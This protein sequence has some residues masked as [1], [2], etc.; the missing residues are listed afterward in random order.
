[1]AATN[2]ACNLRGMNPIFS[3]VS[4]AP[5]E[6]LELNFSAIA[7]GTHVEIQI[8]R[9]A[10]LNPQFAMS[11][12][13]QIGPEG[14]AAIVLNTVDIQP[15]TF[16]LV[17]ARVVTQP[18]QNSVGSLDARVHEVWRANSPQERVLFEIAAAPRALS[19]NE[20]RQEVIEA[21]VRIE[22]EFLTP[23]QAVLGLSHPATRHFTAFAFVRGMLIGTKLRF[24]N[25]EIVPAPGGIDD[26]D[27]LLAVN[28][29]LREQTITGVQFPNSIER[30]QRSTQTNPVCVLHFPAVCAPSHL[31]VRN[32]AV[33]LTNE[34]L[35]ALALTRDA[36]GRVFDCV[37]LEAATGEAISYAES[38]NYVGN[39]LTGWLS[40]ESADSIER[41]AT[42]IGR[43]QADRLLVSLYK[44]ARSEPSL[45]F[46]YVRFWAVL[47][48]LADARE[49]DSDAPLV[50][51]EGN[52]M[53]DGGRRL[54]ING[55][56]SSV[57]NLMR[58]CGVGSTQRNWSLINTWFAFRSAAAH[59]GSRLNFRQLT[60]PTVRAFAEQA[61]AEIQAS[62]HDHFL[63]ELK[64]DTKLLLMRRLNR[65]E[66]W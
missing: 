62:A 55:G 5:G 45:D 23:V 16:E 50:D 3:R 15:G 18:S 27:S 52:Q 61:S 1:M 44:D 19:H 58:E 49:Y 21:E 26:T 33:A 2:V 41:L 53:F 64:E 14:S 25:F 59:H 56:V 20:L 43:S 29:F 10:L 24:R 40:G 22:Q 32:Y 39:L 12:G 66:P 30:R 4:I 9:V 6:P 7:A 37:V 17:G 48:A 35:L 38:G 60:R 31:D 51:F 57:F 34:V 8:Y 28:K 47:E 36:S 46:Q 65:A 11:T 54:T 13:G 63:W 42:Q